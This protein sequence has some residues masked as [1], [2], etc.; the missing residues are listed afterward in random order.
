VGEIR[1]EMVAERKEMEA[2]EMRIKVGEQR[3]L[4]EERE[5]DRYEYI[6][7]FYAVKPPPVQN[8]A[9]F[10]WALTKKEI[11]TMSLG[12]TAKKAEK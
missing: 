6:E 9:V 1:Q 4:T 3:N 7:L 11:E 10:D 12:N 5:G 8:I 2:Q